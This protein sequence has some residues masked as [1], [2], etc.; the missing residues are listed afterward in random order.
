M[1]RKPIGA[2]PMTS[3]E[4]KRRHRAKLQQE[5]QQQAE[6]E[7]RRRARNAAA[8]E[9]RD[10]NE[11]LAWLLESAKTA[12]GVELIQFRDG[13]AEQIADV[14]IQKLGR[15]TKLRELVDEL[16]ARVTRREEGTAL[17]RGVLARHPRSE[18]PTDD[19]DDDN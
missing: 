4:R 6:A 9:G 1:G 11:H 2:Q 18:P 15:T 13:T 16:S 7:E 19:D 3:T 12:A 5:R 14:I 10:F 17:L 8:R